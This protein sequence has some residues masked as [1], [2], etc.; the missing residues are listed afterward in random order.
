MVLRTEASR[1][2][3][4]LMINRDLSFNSLSGTVPSFAQLTSLKTLYVL[5]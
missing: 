5:L 2:D 3:S 4:K 1:S